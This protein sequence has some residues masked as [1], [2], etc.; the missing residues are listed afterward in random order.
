MR[1]AVQK[2]DT[3]WFFD[4]YDNLHTGKAAN[5]FEND[6][7][8]YIRVEL[9]PFGVY[10]VKEKDCYPDKDT[11]L[12]AKKDQEEARIERFMAEIHTKEDLIAFMYNHT[13]SPAEEYTDWTAREAVRR[14]AA[15]FGIIL[16]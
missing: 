11:C 4:S 10:L 1:K 3:V 5:R 6:G 9:S 15:L 7:I 12:K 14:K 2:N 13:V 8:S 16:E